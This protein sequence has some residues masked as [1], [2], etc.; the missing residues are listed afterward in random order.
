MPS[1]LDYADIREVRI[2]PIHGCF[3]AEFIYK[4]VNIKTNTDSKKVLGI[5]R[6]IDNWL[7]CISNTN[8]SLIVDGKHLKSLNQWYNKQV[9]VLMDGKPNGFWSHQLARLTE[10][11]NRQMRD[12]VNKAAKIVINH[13]RE[14]QI[15][16]VVFGG[17]KGQKNSANMGNKT[18]Q[19]FVQI[20]TGRLKTRISQLCDLYGLQF[21]ET[22]ESYTSKCSFVDRDFLPTIGAKPEGWKESGRRIK[23]GLYCTGLQQWR[24]N[25][26]CNGAANIIRKVATM[27][28]LDL[29]GFGRG[30]K[31][32][33]L[34]IAIW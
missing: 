15:G 24:I 32:A 7:T 18:N 9:A 4:S 11:R 29:S 20:P 10:K 12:A 21:V 28:G 26:D 8:T 31:T 17:N 33:P 3:Y 30:V 27:L 2:L 6:G 22:E 23:R 5:D 1:N 14:N 19:K 25:A 13:C 16:T 34:R